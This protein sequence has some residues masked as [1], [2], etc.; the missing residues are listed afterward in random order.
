MLAFNIPLVPVSVCPSISPSHSIVP[1]NGDST[2]FDPATVLVS[3][4]ITTCDTSFFTAF[5][6]RRRTIQLFVCRSVPGCWNAENRVELASQM[7]I[8]LWLLPLL[9]PLL[10]D[11]NST[12]QQSHLEIISALVATNDSQCAF[13]AISAAA[14]VFAIF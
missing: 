1:A 14:A 11:C 12:D 2:N 8:L 4:L 7:T 6:E 3:D 13:A 9:L 5:P 10:S